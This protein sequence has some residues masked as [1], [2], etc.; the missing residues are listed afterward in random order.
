MFVFSFKMTRQQW[1]LA[2]FGVVAV[3]GLVVVLAMKPNAAASAAYKP[4]TATDTAARVSFLQSLGY[5]AD[6]QSEEVREVQIPDR[7]DDVF[8]QYNALQKTVGMDLEP[9][10]GVRV[11]CWTY[12]V[13]NYPGDAPA[14]AH[15]YTLNDK[16]I[17]GDIA[18]TEQGGFLN[19]LTKLP[20]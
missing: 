11:K 5:T 18:S 7:F 15:L 4:V 1:L 14:V 17:G 20:A 13:T 10:R 16:I 2:L 6:P 19:A 12:T 9:Y 8:T 3:I